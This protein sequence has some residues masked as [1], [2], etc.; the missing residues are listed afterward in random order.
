[1]N[2]RRKEKEKKNFKD[3]K[4]TRNIFFVTC[5][6]MYALYVKEVVEFWVEINSILFSTQKDKSI[7]KHNNNI[8]KKKKQMQTTYGTKIVSFFLYYFV[9]IIDEIR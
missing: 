1:M 3:K 7:K 6:L 5:V 9:S 4:T 2:R 8:T